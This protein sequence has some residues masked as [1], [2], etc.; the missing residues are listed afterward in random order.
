MRPTELTWVYIY[1]DTISQELNI[2]FTFNLYKRFGNADVLEK[3]IYSRSFSDPFDALAHKHL[4]D[5]LTKESVVHRLKKMN[6]NLKR[7][8]PE[9]RDD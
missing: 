7:L 8:I 3:L 1:V 6:P 9:I 2:G 5:G 4:L